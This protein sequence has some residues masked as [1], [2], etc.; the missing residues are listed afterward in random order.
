[1]PTKVDLTG[2]SCTL[3]GT[4]PRPPQDDW[5][6]GSPKGLGTN[7][8]GTSRLSRFLRPGFSVAGDAGTGG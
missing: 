7:N 1:M 8:R 4:G 3:K 6:A 5:L 2:A